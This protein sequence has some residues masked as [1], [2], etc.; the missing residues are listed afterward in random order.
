MLDVIIALMPALVASTII[1][2]FRAL[3]ITAVSAGACVLCEYGWE[4]IGHKELTIGDLSAV[5]TGIILAFNV[6][7]NMPIWELII[8]DIVAII[9][10]KML[11]GGI[12]C[13]FVNPALA[14]RVILFFSFTSDMT[15]YVIPSC[16]DAISS[17]TPISMSNDLTWSMLPD[18]LLGKHGG[19]MGEVCILALIIG[20]IYLMVRGVIKPIIPVTFILSEILFAWLFGA[21]TPVLSALGGGLILGAT[22]MATD[23][24]TSPYTDLG[25]LIFGIGCGFITAAIRVFA[26]SSG[27]VSF[28]ILLMNILVPYINDL[29]MP[30]PFG[31]VKAK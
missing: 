11:F 8:G 24:V 16:A 18:L 7:V 28:A 6:P 21:N 31:G 26:N 19:V 25:K 3:L 1:F 29:T 15:N 22:F 17:A 2:G 10:V 13:N 30:K 14:G 4:K 5:V 27:G 23:Y 12:G 9:V 20:G